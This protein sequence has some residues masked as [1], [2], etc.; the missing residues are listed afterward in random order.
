MLGQSGAACLELAGSGGRYRLHRATRVALTGAD[1]V[2][3]VGDCVLPAN[4]ALLLPAGAVIDIGA[5]RTGAYGYLHVG[6]GIT[7]PHILG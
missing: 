3:C 5:A 1:M 6:G 4:T 2:A 7:T